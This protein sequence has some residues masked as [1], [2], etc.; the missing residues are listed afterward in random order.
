MLNRKA[1][2][3]SKNQKLQCVLLEQNA[4]FYK[5]LQDL[6]HNLEKA[7]KGTEGLFY[8]KIAYLLSE[9][10]SYCSQMVTNYKE[11]VKYYEMAIKTAGN[12]P[13]GLYW[14]NL[15]LAYAKLKDWDNAIFA[16]KKA[17]P[18]LKKEEKEG[19]KHGNQIKIL[20]LEKMLY[21]EYRK[22]TLIRKSPENFSASNK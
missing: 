11:A 5:K 2:P 12:R 9:S 10:D 18:L 19:I 21:Q 13:C 8:N 16:I 6:L 20:Q 14:S 15:S 1:K 3:Q 17:I 7:P 22:R 4:D